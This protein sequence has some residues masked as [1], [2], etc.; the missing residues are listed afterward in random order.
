MSYSPQRERNLWI[1]D[2]KQDET[3]RRRI[4]KSVEDL[5]KAAK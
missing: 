2:A 3:R 1:E 4:A 5:R